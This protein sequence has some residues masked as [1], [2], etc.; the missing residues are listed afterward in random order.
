MRRSQLLLCTSALLVASAPAVTARADD[1]PVDVY[2]EA[3]ERGSQRFA[4]GDYPGARADFQ[5]AYAVHADPVLIF[6]IASTYRRE[7]DR[8]HAIEL[9]RAFLARAEADDPRRDLARHTIA[10]LGAE[11][12][13]ERKAARD[14]R[15]AADLAEAQAKDAARAR[16]R[17]PARLVD[18]GAQGPGSDE[19]REARDD[20]ATTGRD[21][22]L[23]LRWTGGGLIGLGALSAGMA[24]FAAVEVE[25]AES[26]VERLAAGRPWDDAQQAAYARGEAAQR[27]TYLYAGVSAAMIT[28]GAVLYVV[29]QRRRAREAPA[30][31]VAP[32]GDGATVSW[33]GRW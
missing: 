26:E 20:P 22:G 27:R 1:A 12:E 17:G 24:L 18:D 9:Y 29:G 2:R 4:D 7:G 8:A 31:T 25:S 11:I 21:A 32:R 10:E 23:A 13:A 5:A 16:A 19:P 3:V 15:E 14:A 30:V 28:T 33:S 6:N